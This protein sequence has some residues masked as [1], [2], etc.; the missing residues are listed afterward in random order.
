MDVYGV[1][2]LLI[3]GTNDQ[4]YVGQTIRTFK[5]RFK[6]H[7]SGDQYIDR[8][9]R[10]RGADMF[11][12]A[13]LK[14]CYS[15]EELDYWEQHFIKYRDTMA[16]NGYNLTAGGDGAQSFHHTEETK[17][18]LSAMMMGHKPSQE[19]LYKKSVAMKKH[20][21][22]PVAHEKASA[23]SKK[24]AANPEVQAKKSAAM[25]KHYEDP[26][27]HAE[28]SAIMVEYYRVHGGPK[29][30]EETKAKIAQTLTGRTDSEEVKQKKRLAQQARRER[31][32]ER[33]ARMPEMIAQENLSAAK[34]PAEVSVD[35]K[36]FH[37]ENPDVIKRTYEL[38]KKAYMARIESKTKQAAA[39]KARR[40]RERIA[41]MPL[42]VAKQNRAAA[43][44]PEKI[45]LP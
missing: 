7:L 36:K 42:L 4:E 37:A 1:I 32:R 8:V 18:Q 39:Q 2:Y 38:R 3:D 35:L 41:K 12:T 25:K 30:S 13:I 26:A 23:A 33:I 28:H 14:L 27:K 6:E 5:E 17:A 9:I 19:T 15:Q 29:H 34:L 40:A 16:P 24:A 43:Q 10:K 22:D 21:E 31:E 45:A 11:A 44:L 20:F